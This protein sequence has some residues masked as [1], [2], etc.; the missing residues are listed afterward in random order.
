MK[1]M[2]ESSRALWTRLSGCDEEVFYVSVEWS[3]FVMFSRC[4]KV[5]KMK[6][7]RQR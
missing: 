1:N 4:V 5:V 7:D 3:V 2:A 6:C